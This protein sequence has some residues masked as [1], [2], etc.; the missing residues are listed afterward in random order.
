M[1]LVLGAMLA[2]LVAFPVFAQKTAADRLESATSDIS[3]LMNASDKGIPQDLINKAQCVVVIPNLKK[4]GFIFGAQYGAGFVSCRKK[5]G[6]GWTAPA[7]VKSEG[8]KFGFLIGGA[9]ADVILLVMN[10]GGMNHLLQ[11]KFTLGGE[12]S[13]AAGP[14]GRDSTAQT[15][16]QMHAEILSYSRQRGIYGGI[17]LN[18]ATLREDDNANKELYGRA[19]KNKEILTD[20]VAVPPAAKP[21]VHA[22]DKVS[23]RK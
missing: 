9:E 1:K 18:G 12:I 2:T 16:A 8:G 22:L 10:Q 14:V 13:A 15:D 5:D 17:S 4:G 21:F 7:A 20:D 3:E 23:S 6:V 11:D 19:L